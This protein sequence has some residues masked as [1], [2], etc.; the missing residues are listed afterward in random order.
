MATPNSTPALNRHQT[1]C[2]DHPGNCS[3]SHLVGS[4]KLTRHQIFCRENPNKCSNTYVGNAAES[5]KGSVNSPLQ[6]NSSGQ[7]FLQGLLTG[8]SQGLAQG[9]QSFNNNQNQNEQQ[10]QN[11]TYVGNL[12]SNQ[13]DTNSTANPFGAGNKYDPNSDRTPL[14]SHF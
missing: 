10:S 1:F 11:K 13:Y 4:Q 6:R 7:R 9:A 3:D 12:S 5:Y 8:I 2:R 14:L